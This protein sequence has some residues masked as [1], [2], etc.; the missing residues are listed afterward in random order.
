MTQRGYFE[1]LMSFD[2]LFRKKMIDNDED[3]ASSNEPKLERCL[4][5]LDLT[6]L[7][8]IFIPVFSNDFS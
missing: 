3:G 6:I 8:I 1:Q 7:G 5:T 4:N 2:F